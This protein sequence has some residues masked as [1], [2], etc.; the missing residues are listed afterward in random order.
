M[1]ALIPAI[2]I[3]GLTRHDWWQLD[4]QDLVARN[5]CRDVGLAT[6]GVRLGS[7][8]EK[9]S[10]EELA[11]AAEKT[12][13]FARVSPRTRSESCRRSGPASTASV[14]KASCAPR[15]EPGSAADLVIARSRS[16]QS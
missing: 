5:V 3:N 1:A 15:I 16:R 14:T 9:M 2:V 8:V 7:D 4:G 12:T 11:A 6:D 10:D 13:L